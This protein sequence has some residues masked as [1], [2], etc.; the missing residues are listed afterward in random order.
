M[1]SKCGCQGA[2]YEVMIKSTTAK[3]EDP[4]SRNVELTLKCHLC[5]KSKAITQKFEYR[6]QCHLRNNRH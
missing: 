1:D 4:F 3:P 6:K 5:L 2:L